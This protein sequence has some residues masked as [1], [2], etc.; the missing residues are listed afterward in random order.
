MEQALAAEV[1]GVNLFRQVQA[2]WNV[3]EP[4]LGP[5][6]KPRIRQG[7]GG[8]Q[9]SPRQRPAGRRG[10]NSR[11]RQAGKGPPGGADAVAIAAVLAQP[12]VDMVLSG[13]VTPTQLRSNL[14]ATGLRLAPAEVESLQPLAS[15]PDL[16]WAR[17]ALDWS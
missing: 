13:A 8:G 5:P 9:G 1:Y 17:S 15:R 14:T 2:T 7:G 16:Y 4:L 6:C 3:L 11:D 12:W 10:A